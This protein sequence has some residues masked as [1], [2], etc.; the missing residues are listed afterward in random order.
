MKMSRWIGVAL[1]TF[2]LAGAASLQ[3]ADVKGEAAA[4][5]VREAAVLQ[6]PQGVGSPLT[7]RRLTEQQ[8]R[9][10][11]AAVFG[12]DIQINGRFE[13]DQRTSGLAAVGSTSS[14]IS[15]TGFA[16]YVALGKD[17]AEQALASAQLRPLTACGRTDQR[18]L[19]RSC[20]SRALADLGEKLYRRP[21]TK[22]E[23]TNITRL[24]LQGSKTL[25]DAKAGIG[26]AVVYLLTSPNFLFRIDK[27]E[28][29]PRSPGAIRLDAFS[30]ASRLS[31][32]LTDGPPDEL[33]MNAART[34]KLHQQEEVASQAGRLMQG[35]GFERATRAFFR[36][37]LSFDQFAVLTKDMNQFPAFDKQ[38]MADAQEQT[39]RMVTDQ[40]LVRKGD[41]RDI[42]TRSDTVL[43][44]RIGGI[45]RVPVASRNGWE[46][47]AGLPNIGRSGLLTDLSFL[48][49][50]SHPG[51]SSPTLR[52]KF[53]REAFLCQHIPPP[54][55]DVD[56]AILEDDHN[57]L[58]RTARDRLTA[59]RTNPSCAGC[60]RLM[61]PIGLALEKFDAE[62][63]FR[64][65]E[66]GAPIDTSGEIDGVAY[67][68]AVG[69]GR[70]LSRNQRVPQCF[71]SNVFRY[72]AGRD[73]LPADRPLIKYY[74]QNFE[75][76]GFRYDALVRLIA[77]SESFYRPVE[78]SEKLQHRF[79][80]DAS[81]PSTI[82]SKL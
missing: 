39:L 6:E 81:R 29:D 69:L 82:G 63:G 73:I 64:E 49:L 76:Q 9:N 13:P 75:R 55:P 27:A 77:T 59:H 23:L 40:L 22:A 14:S 15:P 45:Y 3:S 18:G 31:Y 5:A 1:V 12:T 51:R 46:A 30:K 66:N 61:D 74:T 35:P 54:P 21:L 62:G 4:P 10:S 34:G 53:V 37:L 80:G 33:L 71:A 7:M 72:G 28:P 78:R 43:T 70:V 68:D 50:H 2:A 67:N 25:G 32:F 56:F 57:S 19:D 52:G 36:D 58:R 8:Y 42:F 26:L 48:A 41:F 79:S 47:L 60:H 24:A 17:I 20:T 65:T 44:R 38:L 16:N 11:I